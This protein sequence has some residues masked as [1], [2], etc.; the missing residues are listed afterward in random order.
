MRLPKNFFLSV[1]LSM[2]RNL[3]RI[4]PLQRSEILADKKENAPMRERFLV[5]LKQLFETV[6]NLLWQERHLHHN[7]LDEFVAD[8]DEDFRILLAEG[9][10]HQGGADVLTR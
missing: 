7:S 8:L 4:V 6:L 2:L 9:L 1:L 3:S 10:L 5:T